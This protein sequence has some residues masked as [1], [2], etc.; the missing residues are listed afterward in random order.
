M[1]LRFWLLLVLTACK[2]VDLGVKLPP[3]GHESIQQE[4]LQRDLFILGKSSNLADQKQYLGTRLQDMGLQ[5]S[6]EGERICGAVGVLDPSLSLR[7]FNDGGPD[8]LIGVAALISLA[9]SF[10]GTDVSRTFCIEFSIETN[11]KNPNTWDLVGIHDLPLHVDHKQMT[12]SS[13]SAKKQINFVALANELRR[14]SKEVLKN[15]L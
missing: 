15:P 1:V 8:F 12:I 13:L 9:K 6:L 10:V 5:I 2:A 14:I 3:K 7:V 4:D 11:D